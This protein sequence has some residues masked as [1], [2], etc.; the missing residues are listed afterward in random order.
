MDIVRLQVS[1]G[2]VSP[3]QTVGI[4]LFVVCLLALQSPSYNSQPVGFACEWL[5][6]HS[7][8]SPLLVLL[9]S[10]VPSPPPLPA[11]LT[12]LAQHRPLKSH[13]VKPGCTGL[14]FSLSFNFPPCVLL[15]FHGS[16]SSRCLG[17]EFWVPRTWVLGAC[18]LVLGSVSLMIY[19][20][21]PESCYI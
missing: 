11:A 3:W 6:G 13:L 9:I 16:R 5:P 15:S 17:L 8:P 19:F 2:I 10:L 7:I 18:K 14:S 4:V 20:V 21:S 1:S 12:A